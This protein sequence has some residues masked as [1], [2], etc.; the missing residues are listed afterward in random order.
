[1]LALFTEYLPHVTL[2]AGLEMLVIVLGISWVLLTKKEATSAMAWCLV[3]LLMPFIG[4]L[5]F[6]V[7]GYGHVVRPL[8]RK[9]RHRHLFH[10]HY[11][12]LRA[13]S[14]PEATY[15]ELGFLAQRVNAFPLRHG[16]RVTFYHET[17]QAFDA[18]LEAI[19]GA[20]KHVHLEYFIY[21][22]DS[23]GQRLIELLTQ[24]AKE[25]VEVRL[26]YDAMGGRSLSRRF[27]RPLT[28]MGGKVGVF[29]PLNPLRSRIQIN[30]RNHR[31][32]TVIDGQIAFTGGMNIGDE[33]LGKSGYFGYWRDEVMKVEGAAAADLQRVFAEDWDFAMRESLIQDAYFPLPQQAG[34]AVVQVAESGPDQEI[35]SIREIYFAAILAARERLWIA[36]PYF[37]PDAGLLDALRLA[38]Y[39][40]LDVRLLT[41]HRPDHYL[42]FYAGRFYWSGMLDVGVK[43]YQYTRGM[44][45][46]K[47]VLVDGR[48]AMLG[49]ANLDIRSLRL[50][51]EAVCLLHSPA[52]I[53]ELEEAYLRDLE[54]ALLTDAKA[55]AERSFAVRLVENGCRLLSPVL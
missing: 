42:S 55:F 9:R 52:V 33:Y 23:T 51:F 34:D 28:N 47:M 45:H 41:I 6:W 16:N 22:P 31:K 19:R 53:A 15:G 50:N 44:M 36:S 29:L 4:V 49:S 18:L 37:V 13:G 2:L 5:L 32:I 21:R 40:G 11:P 27:M 35:N 26:L 8:R 54:D 10:A 17:T 46:T 24:K 48:W 14:D 39:R 43:L 25:G 12:T 3:V 1:M 20:R 30:L 7:F 38:R